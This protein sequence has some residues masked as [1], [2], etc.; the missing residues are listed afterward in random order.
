M[1]AGVKVGYGSDLVKDPEAQSEEFLLRSEVMSPIDIIR[2]ATLV[3]AEIVRMAGRV[4]EI[5]EGMIGDL[6]VAGAGKSVPPLQSGWPE[7]LVLE[8]RN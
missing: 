6:I 1:H 7:R 4:G 5:R 2:S 8:R 3:G